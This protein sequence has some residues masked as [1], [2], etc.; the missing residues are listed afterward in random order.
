MTE[1]ESDM[2]VVFK[3]HEKSDAFYPLAARKPLHRC[4]ACPVSEGVSVAN[5]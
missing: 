2:L 1:R 5:D 3:E 4:D